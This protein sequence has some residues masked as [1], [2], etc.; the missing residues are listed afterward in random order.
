MRPPATSVVLSTS[1]HLSASSLEE[2]RDPGMLRR[3]DAQQF[4]PTQVMKPRSR[5]PL[6]KWTSGHASY[7]HY[8]DVV[9]TWEIL[10]GMNLHKFDEGLLYSSTDPRA[11]R[12][13]A[14]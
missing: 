8:C 5:P 6:E 14:P 9:P 3:M 1:G 11:T 10:L 12:I 2:H 13:G 4:A 7:P